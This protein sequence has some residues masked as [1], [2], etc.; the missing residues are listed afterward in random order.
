MPKIVSY[1]TIDGRQYQRL[2]A[3]PGPKPLP[4]EL[5]RQRP[6]ITLDPFVIETGR[7]QAAKL[8]VSFSRYIEQL[9]YDDCIHT[10]SVE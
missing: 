7:R 1:P 10:K 4:A 3:R 9:I 6:G 5:K 2:A 8:G